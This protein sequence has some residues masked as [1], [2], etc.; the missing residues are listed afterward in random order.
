[1][2]PAASTALTPLIAPLFTSI[3]FWLTALRVSA[4][5]IAI[6]AGFS[7]AKIRGSFTGAANFRVNWTLPPGSVV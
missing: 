5:S 2:R 1:V 7:V 3:R 4:T 6:R